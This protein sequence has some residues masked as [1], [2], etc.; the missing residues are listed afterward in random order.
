MLSAIHKKVHT[1]R[2]QIIENFTTTLLTRL[3]STFGHDLPMIAPKLMD[4]V[5]E[6]A[7][8]TSY[9]LTE[10]FYDIYLRVIYPACC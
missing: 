8:L 2:G 9:M 5:V 1:M 6:K 10:L 3:S 7:V 4:N